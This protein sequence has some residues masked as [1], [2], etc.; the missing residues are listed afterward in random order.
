MNFFSLAQCLCCQVEV[1]ATDRSLFQGSPTE[2]GVSECHHEASIMRRPWPT[3][4]AVAPL[5]EKYSRA[6]VC[7]RGFLC[8]SAVNNQGIEREY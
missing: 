1:S 5:K 6:R 8:G 2:C 3:G 7:A 4:G